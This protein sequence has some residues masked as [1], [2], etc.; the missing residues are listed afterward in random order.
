MPLMGFICPDGVKTKT[1]EC[2]TA[3]RLKEQLPA[4][5]CKALPLLKRMAKERVWEGKPS[6]TQLLNGTREVLLKITEPYFVSPD[7]KTAAVIGSGVHSLLYKLTEVQTAEETLFNELLQGTYDMYDPETRTLY[8]YKTWGT[9]KLVKIIKGAPQEKADALFDVTLQLHQYML[10]IKEKYPELPIDNLAVQVISRE[11]NLSYA[12][13]HGITNGSP[14]III[15][16]LPEEMVKS[17]FTVKAERLSVALQTGWA[18]PCFSRETWNGKKCQSYCEVSDICKSIGFESE[19]SIWNELNDR[20]WDV[21]TSIIQILKDSR[22]IYST[23]DAG[24]ECD[25]RF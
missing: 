20:L 10:L 15:P 7:R 16:K 12:A 5:R 13:K 1:E 2:F 24:D 14:L 4:G 6:T 9:Y 8:D 25:F 23:E 22:V 11:T 3:C 18:P 19:H 21:E 17:Y